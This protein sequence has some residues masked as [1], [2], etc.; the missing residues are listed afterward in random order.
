[1]GDPF[2]ARHRK[3]VFKNKEGVQFTSVPL[4]VIDDAT[5]A[6]L[7]GSYA[8]DDEGSQRTRTVLVED[9]VLKD[10]LYDRFLAQKYGRR[11]TGNG[12]R[13]SF[14]FRAEP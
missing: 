5:V 9:G 6:G 1:L 3:G 14:R 13:M 7:G 11:T 10:F 4:T 2:E 8:L 12:R